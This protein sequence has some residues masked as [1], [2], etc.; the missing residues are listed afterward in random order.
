MTPALINKPPFFTFQRVKDR[1]MRT[2]PVMAIQ[3]TIRRDFFL[4]QIPLEFFTCWVLYFQ[5]AFLNPF[6][7]FGRRR[8]PFFRSASTNSRATA[9]GAGFTPCDR[10]RPRACRLIRMNVA[11]FLLTDGIGVL[12]EYL[13]RVAVLHSYP[14]PRRRV[15]RHVFGVRVLDPLAKFVGHFRCRRISTRVLT[16]YMT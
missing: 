11:C 12:L 10:S 5:H 9:R 7:C 16:P 4:L 14:T 15:Q 2:S 13:R 8:N 1:M 6:R 3:T